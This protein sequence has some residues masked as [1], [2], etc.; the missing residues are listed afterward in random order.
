MGGI[1]FTKMMQYMPLPE[2]MKF[3]ML[4]QLVSNC[5]P[6][7]KDRTVLI[8]MVLLA[9]FDEDNDGSISKIKDK[10]LS[11][12]R[13]YLIQ[14]FESESTAEP[15]INIKHINDCVATLPRLLRIFLGTYSAH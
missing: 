6:I 3:E 2:D 12:L 10:V 8:F 4:E 1:P 15:H 5:K 14:K 9:I 13:R 7:F 11:I